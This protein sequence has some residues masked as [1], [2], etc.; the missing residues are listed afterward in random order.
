MSLDYQGI[1]TYLQENPP[2][3]SIPSSGY[4]AYDHL[5]Q[6]DPL[7]SFSNSLLRGTSLSWVIDEMEKFLLN[8]T[9]LNDLIV[10]MFKTRDVRGKGE[11]LL[12][13]QMF[14]CI[15]AKYPEAIL[16]ILDLIPRYGYWKDFFHLALTNYGLLQPAMAI[17]YDQLMAD[18]RALNEG[19]PLSL[20]AK[21]V[22]KEG[23]SGHHF[24]KE[25]ANYIYST[26]D[27]NYSKRMSA[28]RRRVS[29]LNAALNTVEVLQCANRWDE[30]EPANVPTIAAKK[31]RA[32]FMNEICS[33]HKLRHP[34]DERRLIC[35]SNFENFTPAPPSYEMD[36]RRYDPI[37]ERLTGLNTLQH[38]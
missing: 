32:A 12:F 10:L 17:A 16:S 4:S 15:Y 38:L 7:E 18:E 33:S 31:C 20:F 2:T 28:L 8:P 5:F 13:R 22:P 36:E 23:K 11:R 6:K 27:M 1:N 19:R 30:I 37:R 24:A 35:R 25:F 29:R 9:L 3:Y 21:W 26:S 14:I 34:R